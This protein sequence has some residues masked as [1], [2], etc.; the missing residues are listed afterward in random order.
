MFGAIRPKTGRQSSSTRKSSN[1]DWSQR[2]EWVGC[3]E[4]SLG[5]EKT[6]IIHVSTYATDLDEN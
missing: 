1:Q 2:N 6:W 3:P 5:F 4:V